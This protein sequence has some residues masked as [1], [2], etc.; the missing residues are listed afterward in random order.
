[1]FS[2]CRNHGWLY[3]FAELPPYERRDAKLKEIVKLKASTHKEQSFS[4]SKGV[5]ADFVDWM[6]SP[7]GGG[8][9]IKEATQVGRRSMKYL[10]SALGEGENETEAS[11]EY[12]DCV[13]ASPNLLINFLKLI[14]EEWRLKA[15]AVLAY[16]QGIS[17]LCDYRKSKGCSDSVLRSFAVTEVY[18]RKCKSTMNRRK[19]IEYNRDLS[20]E[21]LIARNS[22]ATLEEMETVIHAFFL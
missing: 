1:M 15:A 14:I 13:I 17:D 3:H 2:F 11:E 20:L 9:S 8:K 4:I 16:L 6:Q 18:I 19:N 10:F 5:G 22:W 7:W 21:T 12:V